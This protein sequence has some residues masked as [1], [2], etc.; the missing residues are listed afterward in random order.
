MEKTPVPCNPFAPGYFGSDELRGFGFASVGENVAI[1]KNCTIIAPE[2]IEIGD[3]VR[4]D[5]NVHIVAAEGKVTLG[6]YIHIGGACHIAGR[7]GVMMNDFS[8]LSQGVRIYSAS[9]DYSGEHMTNPMVPD[10]YLGFNVAPVLLGR[11]AIIGSGSVV[12]PGCNIGEGVAVGALAL[13][14]KS[15]PPW[16][17]Y[18]GAPARRLRD[19]SR[20]LLE[21]EAEMETLHTKHES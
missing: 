11:H 21:L 20:R 3:H 6:S 18:S 7:G 12:L 15:L 4:I 9:D 1:A 10:E 19:R 14:T 5:S 16:G 17:I 8:G 13:V 2:R